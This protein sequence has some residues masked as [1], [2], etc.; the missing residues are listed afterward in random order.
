[1]ETLR[2]Y[3]AGV[4]ERKCIKEY[5]FNTKEDGLNLTIKPGTLVQI[6][7]ERMMKDERFWDEPL[8]YNPD[9]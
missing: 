9:R 6:H 2:L 1:M 4:L 5:T 8:R 3:P 7:A